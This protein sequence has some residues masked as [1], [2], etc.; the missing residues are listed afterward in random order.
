MIRKTLSG[1]TA[2]VCDAVDIPAVTLVLLVVSI[3]YIDCAVIAVEDIQ[4]DTSA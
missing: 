3:P 1:R 2:A 4:D